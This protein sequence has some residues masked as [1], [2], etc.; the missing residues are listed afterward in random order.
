MAT[1]I[2][3]WYMIKTLYTPIRFGAVDGNNNIQ[4][5]DYTIIYLLFLLLL[6]IF[7]S[8]RHRQNPFTKNS[9]ACV[10]RSSIGVCMYVC[11]LIIYI[12][13]Y[14]MYLYRV[15]SSVMLPQ[16]VRFFFYIFNFFFKFL[17]P[18]LSKHKWNVIKCETAVDPRMCVCVSEC[19]IVVLIE[20]DLPLIACGIVDNFARQ[21]IWEQKKC[22]TA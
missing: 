13:Y 10:T 1:E 11:L 12:I 19:N 5:Y 17:A 3:G 4:Y 6:L 14:I 2:Y 8:S 20:I 9:L 22:D 16:R 7:F 15:A 21:L 18:C